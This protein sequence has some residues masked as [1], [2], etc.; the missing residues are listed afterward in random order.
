[1]KL[2]L[3]VPCYNEEKNVSLFYDTVEKV[4]KSS[5]I[6]YEYIFINDGSKD[7]TYLELKKLAEAHSE[8]NI[9]VINFSRNFGKE[10]AMYA[11]LKE[12]IGEYTV[13]IDADLQQD[14]EYVLQMLDKLE[15]DESYDSVAAYQEK[16]KEGKVLRA[17]KTSFY[18]LINKVSQVEFV[19]GAS[20]FRCL[21]RSMVD[22]I[23]ELPE[24]N[25]F[26]KGIFS[27]VGFRTFYMPYDVLERANGVSSWSFWKL[28]RYAIEGFVSFTTTPLRMATLFGVFFAFIAF[29]YM[30]V[31]IIQKLCFSID[32]P[33]YATIICLILL[34]GGIQLLCLGIMGEYLARTYIETKRRPIYVMK[35][36]IDYKDKKNKKDVES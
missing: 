22:A 36:K 1:M 7:Q 27:W 8:S 26:S 33:G 28:F 32:I 34:I 5:G 20:D 18:H 10:S 9:N 16:R 35:N 3:I 14:P 6:S 23:L 11:G 15:Q 24:N 12:S 19:D 30:I 25:R 31:V 29:L 17:F 21:R 2:S 13:I 4:F